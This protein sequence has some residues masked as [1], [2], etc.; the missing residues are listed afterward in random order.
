[1][2]QLAIRLANTRLTEES[3]EIEKTIQLSNDRTGFYRRIALWR[4]VDAVCIEALIFRHELQWM[5]RSTLEYYS[6]SS[7]ATSFVDI[8][9]ADI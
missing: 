1:M 8:A 2:P 4:L 9:K 3:R 5:Q 7:I 6:S